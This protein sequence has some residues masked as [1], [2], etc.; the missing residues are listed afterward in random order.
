MPEPLILPL[1]DCSDPRLVGGKAAG[2]GALLRLGFQ[3]P[4]GICVTTEAVR[5][6]IR[7]IAF[8]AEAA[9]ARLVT[10]GP[11]DRVQW[12]HEYQQ[13]MDQLAVPPQVLYELDDALQTLELNWPGSR[14]NWWAVRSSAIDE[15]GPRLSL[16]G[17][18]R[19]RL[20]L[21]REEIASAICT[22]WAS[23]WTL[24]ALT[25]AC[26]ARLPTMAVLIQPLLAARAAGVAFSCHPVTGE[27]HVV[28]VNAVPGLAEP[29]V[30]GTVTPD[31]FLIDVPPAQPAPTVRQCAISEKSAA[32]VVT[33]QGL[34]DHALSPSRRAAPSLD[35]ADVLMLAQLVKQV[36]A[37]LRT[38]V[39][40]EWAQDETALWLLQ[41]RAIAPHSVRTG[42]SDATS[43]WSRANFK[44]TMPDLPSPLG[45]AF[46]EEFMEHG[47]LRHYHALGCQIPAG[48]SSFRIV[49][50]RP[51]INVS[52]FQS[53]IS[54]L[55]GDPRLV[56]EQMGGEGA[57][58]PHGPAPLPWR[59]VAR[60]GLLMEAKIRRAAWRAEGWFREMKDMARVPQDADP[61][62]PSPAA[63]LQQLSAINQRL[64]ERD[65][66][67]AIVGGVSQAFMVLG[68]LLERRLGLEW[69]AQLNASLQG[70]GT[71]ISANQ[72]HRLAV[73][74][75]TARQ[76]PPARAF[77]LAAPWHPQGFRAALAGTT[78]LTK[79]D[80]YLHDYGH[81]GLAESDV[82]S[83]RFADIPEYVLGVIRAQL[84]A[85]SPHSAEDRA[86]VTAM[87]RRAALDDIRQRFGRRRHEWIFFRW[88]HRRLDR[89]LA[90]REANRHHLMYFS[91]AARRLELRLA[92][93]FVAT[94]RLNHRDDLFFLLPDEI[95]LLAEGTGLRSQEWVAQR[96]AEGDRFARETPP[97]VIRGLGELTQA[98]ADHDAQQP[99]PKSL[100][101]LLRGLPIG[102]GVGE[103]PVRLVLTPA[104]AGTVQR[105]DVIVTPV[106]DP[107]LAPVFGLAAGLVAEMGGVLSHGAII[108]REYGLP[109][110]ANVPG[111][112][113]LL[114]D[115]DHVI[116]DGGR[117]EVRRDE[118]AVRAGT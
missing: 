70:S 89:F 62:L 60:A 27:P 101:V 2:L 23:C 38:D 63:V 108:A 67:F 54:Q 117:G 46:L 16:A 13:Q 69:R 15:D 47:I 87:K 86:Q 93:H 11:T 74:A 42:L 26:D 100:G 52:L 30:N 66:T 20:G 4:P 92:D 83:P 31:S 41:A 17:T 10:A 72:I 6:A 44:E 113:H 43:T 105:G 61:T 68:L 39:D 33:E 106:I 3:V 110:V 81:R 64:R 73:L 116:V 65:L 88:W 71:V 80:A 115:G 95:R 9:W 103:G 19:S 112:T 84:L 12:L 107:G 37:R 25:R 1:P 77:I 111:A 7:A 75:E 55:R 91:A 50:G 28:V 94:G 104:D 40:V 79:F 24:S 14:V 36:A 49:A 22:V 53:F 102:A 114:R 51:Y 78:F 32:R 118:R 85:P 109:T 34:V 48:T 58:T 59:K 21:L 82:A 76:E 29:L 97:D 96:R 18:Y 90:L 57:P 5:L 98:S 45:L 99:E 8:D 35:E 56:T